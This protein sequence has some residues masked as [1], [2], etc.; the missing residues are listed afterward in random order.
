[1]ERDVGREA[2]RAARVLEDRAA[3]GPGRRRDP[4]R[5][6]QRGERHRA[7]VRLVAERQHD[8]QRVLE[9]VDAL[10]PRVRGR[11][12]AHVLVRDREVDV[13]QPQRGQRRLRLELGRARPHVGVPARER[14]DRRREQRPL[15]AGERRDVDVAGD[16][17]RR[18]RQ[19]GGRGLELHEDRLRARDEPPAGL[20]QPD[21]PAVAVE[22]RD[23]GLALERR[24]L[25][26][27]RR[28]R[29][30]ERPRGGGDRPALGD[31]AQHAHP[32][33]VEGSGGGR[34]RKRSLRQSV[35]IV[36]CACGP[37]LAP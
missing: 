1:V 5:V 13:A 19:L 34:H 20:G 36:T 4:A 17:G 25:L 24:E 27:D 8:A 11:R 2:G 21:A 18:G 29:E 15:G 16:V 28:G 33:H 35:A 30:R 6:R 12:P 10:E 7:G 37:R 31:L 3:G 14:G 26:R 32:A 9:Q 22:Q 23:A